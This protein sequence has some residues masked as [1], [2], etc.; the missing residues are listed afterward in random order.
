MKNKNKMELNFLSG[1]LGSLVEKK[2]K[3][4]CEYYQGNYP[5]KCIRRVHKLLLYALYKKISQDYQE[6]KVIFIKN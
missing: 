4:T 1:T 6:S 2:Y 3:I 5:Q